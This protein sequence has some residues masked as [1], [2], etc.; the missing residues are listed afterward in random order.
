MRAPGA[1]EV[2]RPEDGGRGVSGTHHRVARRARDVVDTAA[3]PRVA[4]IEIEVDARLSEREWSA[5]LLRRVRAL[6]VSRDDAL[7][8]CTFNYPTASSRFASISWC[9]W[10][11]RQQADRVS[12]RPDALVLKIRL[13]PDALADLAVPAQADNR[14]T[15]A[16]EGRPAHC[17]ALVTGASPRDRAIGPRARDGVR[18][19]GRRAPRDSSKRRGGRRSSALLPARP[20]L[21]AASAGRFARL[22]ARAMGS[23]SATPCISRRELTTRNR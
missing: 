14:N 4:A 8:Y 2:H 22:P 20:P 5:R 12:V 16:P 11:G 17:R 13:S 21:P 15:C 10:S 19:A 7:A 18:R 6:P 3:L 1:A 9:A 23:S